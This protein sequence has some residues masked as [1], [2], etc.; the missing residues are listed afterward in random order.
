[1]SK[2]KLYTPATIGNVGPGFDVLGL[3]LEGLGDILTLELVDGPSK[4]IEVKGTDA[5]KVPT[6]PTQNATVI[7][8]EAFLRKRHL[9]SGVHIWC[10]RALPISGGLGSSAAAA[11][12]GALGAA[13]ASGLAYSNEEILEA[14]LAGESHVAGKH[15]DNI[16]PCYLGGMTAVLSTQP[17]VVQKL[18]HSHHLMVIVITPELRLSTKEARAVLPP[19]LSTQQWTQQMALAIGLTAGLASGDERTIKNCLQDPFAE[20]ARGPLIPQFERVKSAALEA[21][22]LG[23]SISGAGPTIFALVGPQHDAELICQK[24][25]QAFLP[26]PSRARVCK[27]ATH[28]AHRI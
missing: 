28:G 8:A 16:A 7:A 13:L 9:T 25:S 6:D 11:T 3:A 27:I 15:L 12:G 17:P 10:E 18:P 21:G 2:V 5:D 1:M 23:C 19:S 24:M 4:I 14:A 20:K 22:A 26:I